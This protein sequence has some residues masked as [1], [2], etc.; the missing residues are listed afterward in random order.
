MRTRVVLLLTVLTIAASAQAASPT[1][2]RIRDT[3]TV[4]FAYREAAAPFSFKDRMG[5]VHGYS[6]ELCSRIAAALKD[7]L[8]LPD[9]AVKW[10]AVD[11]AN[12][13]DAVASGRV[14]AECGTTTI[15][16]TRMGQV[17][18]S[19]P[20]FIDGGSVLVRAD[21]KI[22]SMADLREHK[23]AVIPA[24]TTERALKAQLALFEVSATIV[25]VK[26]PAEGAAMLH[27]GKVDGFAGDRIVLADLQRRA[28]NASAYAVLGSD[29]SYEPYAIV[30]RR[31][32]PDFRLAV[33]RA[34]VGVYKRGEIDPI[35]QRWLGPLGPPGPLLHSM[36]YLNSLPE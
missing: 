19:L 4:T 11:A 23:I 13:L 7:T 28:D 6:V 5:R 20:I 2:D 35:F 26:D 17:D 8:K 27:A 15:T 25:P 16:L 32:D 31:D 36:F 33:N 34:L 3:R 12:R 21:S 30:V 1:L 24:T 18:F 9:L 29:F 14:D 22:Q 10:V